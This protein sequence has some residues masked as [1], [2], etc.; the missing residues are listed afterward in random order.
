MKGPFV[1]PALFFAVLFIF[2]AGC[3]TTAPARTDIPTAGSSVTVSIQP[4]IARYTVL[5]SSAPG[6]GLTPQI[7]GTRPPDSL[8]YV[9]KTDYGHFVLWDAPD[10]TVREL[11]NTSTSG[12]QTKVYWTYIG[13]TEN[14]GRPP[15]HVTLDLIDRA[16]GDTL[17]HGE[18]TIDWDTRNDTAVIG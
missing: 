16:T 6:I 4:D 15:V 11:G 1:F 14:G 12:N 13:E 9:W 18:Q 3:S 17:G 8:M 5:M 2:G 10:Y 7:N